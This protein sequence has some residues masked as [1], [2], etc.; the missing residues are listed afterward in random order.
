MRIY[1]QVEFVCIARKAFSYGFRV[2]T[3]R[4]GTFFKN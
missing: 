4:A 3:G 2:I 1:S